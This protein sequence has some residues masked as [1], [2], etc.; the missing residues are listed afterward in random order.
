[1]SIPQTFLAKVAKWD[2]RG[3][4]ALTIWLW[5]QTPN[6]FNGTDGQL[7]T[8]IRDFACLDGAMWVPWSERQRAKGSMGVPYEIQA[9]GVRMPT[10][11]E[12]LQIFG[13][14]FTDYAD[15]AIIASERF[16]HGKTQRAL[17]PFL[18]SLVQ[19]ATTKVADYAIAPEGLPDDVADRPAYTWAFRVVEL[20]LSPSRETEDNGMFP[21]SDLVDWRRNW[22]PT[23][24]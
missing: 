12:A 5:G 11:A 23:W 24:A 13:D 10:R 1:V 3:P 15:M 22:W 8:L 4:H 14:L 19:I 6:Q 2:P 21:D 20:V 17:D 7:D 16:H 9:A 18:S